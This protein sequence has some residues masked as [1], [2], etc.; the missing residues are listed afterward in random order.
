MATVEV[1]AGTDQYLEFAAG[2]A[3]ISKGEVI[4]QLVARVRRLQSASTEQPAPWIPDP[5]PVH[6]D[7]AGHRICG[8]FYPGPGRIEITTG[9]LAGSAY[10]T[11][12]AAAR[13]VVGLLRP[14]VSANRN[15]WDFWSVS[16]DGNP[17]QTIRHPRR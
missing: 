9:D 16:A 15:G 13:A 6:A 10:P 1:D 2:I 5:V 7:Y 4:A 12:S 17:L 14:A 11:P 8:V 3:G